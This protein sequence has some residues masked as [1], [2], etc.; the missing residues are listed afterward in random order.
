LHCWEGKYEHWWQDNSSG[1]I[2]AF[3]CEWRNQKVILIGNLKKTEKG[4]EIEN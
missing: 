1:G 3:T 2:S 4:A